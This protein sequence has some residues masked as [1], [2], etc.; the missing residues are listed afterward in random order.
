MLFGLR[1]NMRESL[2]RIALLTLV[3]YEHFGSSVS[4]TS[5]C[6]ADLQLFSSPLLVVV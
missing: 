4:R 2:K 6:L 3:E 1:K 5:R